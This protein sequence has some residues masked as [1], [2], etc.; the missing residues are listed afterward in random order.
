M[1]KLIFTGAALIASLSMAAKI[2]PSK[3]MATWYGEKITGFHYGDIKLS[4]GE[5]EVKNGALVGG[6]FE[7]DMT[8]MSCGDCDPKS[9]EKLVG[10][11]K[12]DDF[13]SADK[14]KNSTLKIKKVTAWNEVD[15]KKQAE[16]MKTLEAANKRDFSKVKVAKPT[17]LIS[18][19]LSIKGKTHPQDIV[20]NVEV[21][22]AAVNA[23]GQMVVDRTKFDVRYGSNKFFDNLGNKAISDSFEVAVKLQAK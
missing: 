5:L 20:A 9:A 22:G 6:S 14:F 1:K 8:S 11:L 2:D 21:N 3:S 23:S 7:V 4:S 10:H 17:H 18:A 19:D 13:F 16:L 12:S 15:K